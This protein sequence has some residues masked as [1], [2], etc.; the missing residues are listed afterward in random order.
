MQC[1]YRVRVGAIEIEWTIWT[2]KDCNT[3]S[4]KFQ[5]PGACSASLG[6]VTGWELGEVR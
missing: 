3:L 6:V 2:C 5:W 4:W 1:F